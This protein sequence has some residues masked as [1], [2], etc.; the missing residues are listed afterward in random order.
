MKV[1]PVKVTKEDKHI[2]AI[3]EEFQDLGYLSQVNRDIDYVTQ[4]EKVNFSSKP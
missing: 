3:S 1:I 4:D 2:H